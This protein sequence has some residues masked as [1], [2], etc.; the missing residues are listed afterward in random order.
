MNAF[1][2]RIETERRALQAPIFFIRA[3]CEAG[4]F[5]S[6]PIYTLLPCPTMPV[7]ANAS[8]AGKENLNFFSHAL[9]LRVCEL[10][11]D[12]QAKALLRRFLGH[13]EIAGF[14]SEVSVSLL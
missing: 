4:V 1:Q 9:D 7:V 5:L 14:V 12:R 11:I 6:P 8:A 10:R 2:K 13:R 3:S